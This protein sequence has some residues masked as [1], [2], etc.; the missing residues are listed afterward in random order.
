MKSIKLTKFKSYAF[1]LAEVLITLGII[2]IVAAILLPNVVGMYKR[3][4]YSNMLKKNFVEINH[5]FEQLESDGID[6]VTMLYDGEYNK[7]IEE[8]FFPKFSGAKLFPEAYFGN[9]M[10]GGPTSQAQYLWRGSNKQKVTS[11][12]FSSTPVKSVQTNSGA[13]IS[14]WEYWNKPYITVDINGPQKKTNTIGMDVFMF[15]IDKNGF[16]RPHGYG[17]Q[18]SSILNNCPDNPSDFGT[19][20]HYCTAR[21]L[22]DNWEMKY[23]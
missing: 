7:F 13:C 17:M 20:G 18:I 6:F 5:A 1:T 12:A 2:G 14:I 21:I 11:G 8:F 9:S 3:K 4:V 22:L 15:Y 23:R 19:G 10:C 16:L